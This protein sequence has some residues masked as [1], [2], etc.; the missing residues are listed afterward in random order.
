MT[1][2]E[3]LL[4]I[5]ISIISS[6]TIW[7]FLQLYT[8]GARK[9]I[10]S[11]LIFLRDECVAFEKYL[12]YN[13]YDNVLQMTRRISDKVCEIFTTIKTF[14]YSR[15]KRLLINT[16]L[17][18]I[19][20]KCH[21]FLYKEIGYSDNKEKCACCEKMCKEIFI[22]GYSDYR[23]TPEKLCYCEPVT[24]VSAKILID[25]N[26]FRAKKI[27]TILTKGFFFNSFPVKIDKLKTYYNDLIDVNLFKN[28][29]TPSIGKEFYLTNDTITQ[30]QYKKIIN[31]LN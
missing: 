2:Q 7:C 20:L 13:D 18:N 11:I 5:A 22:I 27:N 16:L 21:R 30:N 25:L 31:S 4:N 19:Y 17:N 24:S 28:H 10:H 9:K 29:I 15:K 12:K 26:L 6:I 23:A 8:F 14:T 1:F 3:I